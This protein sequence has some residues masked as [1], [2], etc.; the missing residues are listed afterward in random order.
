MNLVGERLGARIMGAYVDALSWEETLARISNWGTARQSRYVCLC[1]VHTLAT[2]SEDSRFQQAVNGADL[3]VADGMP[4]ALALRLAGFR[5]QPRIGG[6][7]LFWQYC[8]L[9]AGAE[10]SIFLYGSTPQTIDRLTERLCSAFPHLRIAGAFSPP[11]RALSADED[12]ATARMINDSGASVVFVG[13]GCPK[14]ELWMA[15]QRGR[16]MAVMLGVG[17][18]FDFHAGTLKRAPLWMQHYGLEWLHRLAT[19]P[20]RLWRRYLVSN[21][22]F[23]FH[24]A[25][26]RASPEARERRSA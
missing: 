5:G 17:A 3:A 26:H 1:N 22:K 2:A 4:V 6:P 19:E 14:Q 10:Q 9:A 18:A 20:G 12:D 16:I 8:S 15:A 24:M 13:L 23:L 21:S 11:F 7:D 25:V